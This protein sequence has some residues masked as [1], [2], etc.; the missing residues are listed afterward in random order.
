M[1]NKTIGYYHTLRGS[2]PRTNDLGQRVMTVETITYSIPSGERTVVNHYDLTEES[3]GEWT[4]DLGMGF[5]ARLRKEPS[6]RLW[7]GEEVPMLKENY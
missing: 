2:N 7:N 4:Q 1:K 3:N 6:E 5:T